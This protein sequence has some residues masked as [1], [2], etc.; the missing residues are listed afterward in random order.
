MLT[1]PE[2]LAVQQQTAVAKVRSTR[3]PVAYTVQSMLAGAYIGIAV[4]LMV[5]AAGPFLAAGSPAARLVSGLVFGIA[6]TLVVIAGGELV[7]SNMMTLTQGALARRIGWGQAGGTMLFCF[8]GNLLGA[9]AFAGVVHLSGVVAPATPGGAMIAS[10]L[11]AK[12]GESSTALFFRAI[13][14]NVLV[15]LAVWSAVRLTSEGARLVVI[16]WCLLAFITSGFEHV[17]ANMTTFGLG[18][19][20]GLPETSWAELGRNM[21]VVGLGNLVGGAVVVGLGYAVVAGPL[22]AATST[23]GTTPDAAPAPAEPAPAAA[24]APVTAG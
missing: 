10:L 9:F 20:G 22:R 15:C 24:P 21:L 17:V 7:T 1:I 16:F 8:A 19:I 13:L 14:C 23:A 6:L 11:E 3:R 4:V 18:V 12:G 5:S 2:A